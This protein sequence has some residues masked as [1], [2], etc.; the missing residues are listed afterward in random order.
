MATALSAPEQV[1]E[2]TVRWVWDRPITFDEFLDQFGP[3]DYYEL[4]DGVAVEKPTVQ[5]EHEKLEIWLRTVLHLYVRPRNLGIVLGS[6]SPVQ[7]DQFRGRLPDLFFVA[8]ERM[9]IVQQ[10]ATYGAP[11]LVIEI[12]SP[13]DRPS[14]VIA[15]ETDFRAIGV[16]EIVFI[17]QPRRRVRVLR[18]R[19]GDYGEEVL[20]AGAL[21]LETLGGIRLDLA[22][23]FTDPR[24]DERQTADALGGE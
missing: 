12:I 10:K 19:N 4:V 16:R 11:D 21:T 17:D 13:N 9:G 6:R 8:Q 2:E 5:L 14:D 23:L 22:W 18:P 1:R 24:P 7:I 20:T 15:L 3:K